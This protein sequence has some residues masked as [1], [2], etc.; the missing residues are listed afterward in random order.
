MPRLRACFA[1]GAALAIAAAA[2]AFAASL[3]AP[4]PPP[5]KPALVRIADK[6]MPEIPP[7][8]TPA[9][10]AA[11]DTGTDQTN[12]DDP[13]VATPAASDL[14]IPVVEYDFSKLPPPVKRMRDQILEAAATGDIEKLRPVIAANG[15]EPQFSFNDIDDPIAYLKSLSGDPEGREILAIL[16]EVLDAGY[17]HADEG[18]PDEI[19]I[20]PYFARYPVDKLTPPQ[21]VELFK[22]IYAGD[23]E[24]MKADGTYLFYRVGITPKGVWKYFV[25]GD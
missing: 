17:V 10:G 9:E 23:F 20:W 18:T 7:L 3:Q 11:T 19:Y 25:A 14:P 16:T 13:A 12:P 21:L 4:F 24:D 2:P 5:A 15:E 22:L 6:V 8:D 1:A